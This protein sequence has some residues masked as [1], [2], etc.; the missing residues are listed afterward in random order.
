MVNIRQISLFDYF[1]NLSLDL[2]TLGKHQ[3]H[4]VITQGGIVLGAFASSMN[5]HL[6]GICALKIGKRASLEYI[7]VEENSRNQ[8]IATQ[9]LERA[10]ALTQDL[11]VD[12]L[13]ALVIPQNACGDILEHLL[14]K[15]GFDKLN[16]ATIA[17]FDYATSAPAWNEF[18]EQRGT[19]ICKGLLKK[20]YKT[21]SFAEVDEEVLEKLRTAMV[22]DFPRQLDPFRL[23]ASKEQKFVPDHSFITLKDGNPAAFA[24]VTTID[25]RSLSF[26]Q[27]SAG[28]KYQ[29]RG[30]FLL[31]LAALIEKLITEQH[32]TRVATLVHDSNNRMQA[33]INGFLQ[34]LA[35]SMKT[36]NSY[37]R[38][39]NGNPE[40]NR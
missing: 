33:L 37:R 17:R 20:G 26:Q 5:Q 25:D 7:F 4:T 3:V 32:Y 38:L 31:P 10:I 8:G 6:M 15:T 28:Y 40:I 14:I 22:D 34:T 12:I 11:N 39:L 27:L 2:P 30:A 9:M 13:S 18:M 1:S 24:T 29:G 23:M 21:V 35:I 19:S 36:Q 16:T